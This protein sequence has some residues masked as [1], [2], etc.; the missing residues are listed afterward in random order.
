ML[1]IV[2]QPRKTN[3]IKESRGK[4]FVKVQLERDCNYS[5]NSS[6]NI[7]LK[8]AQVVVFNSLCVIYFRR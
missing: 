1:S 3:A 7:F 5:V 4:L 8:N 2:P 6:M